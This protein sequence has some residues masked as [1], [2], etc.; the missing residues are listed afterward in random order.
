MPPMASLKL[1]NLGKGFI[2]RVTFGF[3]GI[4]PSHSYATTNRDLKNDPTFL[5]ALY[6]TVDE[7]HLAPPFRNQL[8]S[9]DSPAHANKRYAF[10]HVFQA[11]R[12]L[13]FATI[14]SRGQWL[15]LWNPR[16]TDAGFAP[17]AASRPRQPRAVEAQCVVLLQGSGAE[18]SSQN[19][20]RLAE[21]WRELRALAQFLFFDQIP[22]SVVVKKPKKP[23]RK[24]EGFI[25]ACFCWMR[26]RFWGGFKR[27]L[28]RK[29]K[30]GTFFFWFYW[31]T[32]RHFSE[33]A[34]CLL[35][36]RYIPRFWF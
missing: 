22:F 34:L 14:R 26:Y 6:A 11:V 24:T 21:S 31:G 8:V 15:P 10:N 20:P 5:I 2:G 1:W 17:S 35:S 23:D 36:C 3:P 13:D 30:A 27:T 4:L 29:P 33:M 28:K 32:K 18:N 12:F 7:T 9:D 16:S 19:A 25:L